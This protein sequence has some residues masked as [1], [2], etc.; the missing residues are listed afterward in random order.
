MLSAAYGR[1]HIVLVHRLTVVTLVTRPTSSD[2]ERF[3]ARHPPS[4]LDVRRRLPEKASS[5]PEDLG[6]G[7]EERYEL[8]WSRCRCFAV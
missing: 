1:L 6:R 5:A 4:K 7:R 8:H 3:T 2:I